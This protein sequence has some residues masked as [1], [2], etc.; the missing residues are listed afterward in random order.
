[1]ANVVID[2]VAWRLFIDGKEVKPTW[3]QFRVLYLFLKRQDRLIS[4]NTFLDEIWGNVE[5]GDRAPD[6]VVRDVRRILGPH[7]KAIETIRKEGYRFNP[8]V[9]T[10][11]IKDSLCGGD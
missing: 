11:E 6:T 9:C 5:V 10:V 4:R 7:K 8:E 1:M 2:S 3:L